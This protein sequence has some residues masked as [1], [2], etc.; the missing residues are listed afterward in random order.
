MSEQN[1][2][3]ITSEQPQ[4]NAVQPAST[5]IDPQLKA[6]LDAAFGD[7][8]T[9]LNQQDSQSEQPA[10]EQP[11]AETVVA[12]AFDENAFY[13]EFNVTSKDE[14]KQRLDEYNALK[15]QTQTPA[16]I[17]FANEESKRI[18]EALRA[19]KV[20][21]VRDY[22]D[23]QDR[24]SSLETMTAEQQLK[25]HIQMQYPTF[26]QQMIDRE[27]SRRYNVKDEA[28]YDDPLDYQIDKAKAEQNVN[29]DAEKAREFFAQ[30]RQKI[31]LPQI[32]NTEQTAD[33]AYEAYKA[34][35]AQAIEAYNTVTVPT[36]TAIKE[37]DLNASFKISDQT[38]QMDFD[39]SFVVDKADLEKAKANA[40]NYQ[41]YLEKNFFHPDGKVNGQRMLQAILRDML[42][43]KYVQ[44]T[45]RQAVNAERKRLIEKETPTSTLQRNGLEAVEKSEF[46]KMMDMAMNV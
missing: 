34:S 37:A 15:Q 8:Q 16:E 18:H 41:E 46:Q 30:Y 42:F 28:D 25:L 44:T 43:D 26:N 32:S 31:E 21:E 13:Q 5:T 22:L 4:E 45:A 2:D 29:A 33:E 6:Q 20:K 11:N 23:A 19:G 36:I 40:L 9:L 12:P 38:N 39:V 24:L 3:V 7:N 10:T 35:N 17:A 14:L 27:Y 1:Q